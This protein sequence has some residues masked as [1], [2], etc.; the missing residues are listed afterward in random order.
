MKLDFK[1]CN[2]TDNNNKA[3]E[4]T[5][6]GLNF[7]KLKSNNHFETKIPKFN[8]VLV[9]KNTSLKTLS[10]NTRNKINKGFKYGLSLVKGTR[11]NIEEIYKFIKNKKVFFRSFLKSIF[12]NL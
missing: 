8:A 4:S 6:E 11:E 7:R 12:L 1:S 9:L 2:K 5:L 10:K 3:I